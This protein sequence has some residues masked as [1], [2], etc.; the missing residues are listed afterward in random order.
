M[1]RKL[2]QRCENYLD[3]SG[4]DEDAKELIGILIDE[5]D[6]LEMVHEREVEQLN[7]QIMQERNIAETW[8]EKY[9]R[10]RDD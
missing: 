1:N 2:I 4:G 8:E 7:D 5:L 10:S 3:S 6:D 9:E